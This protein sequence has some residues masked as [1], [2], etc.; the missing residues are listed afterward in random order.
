LGYFASLRYDKFGNSNFRNRKAFTRAF[1]DETFGLKRVAA[2][3][4]PA[5]LGYQAAIKKMV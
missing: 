2:I 5:N 3:V 4:R 1:G